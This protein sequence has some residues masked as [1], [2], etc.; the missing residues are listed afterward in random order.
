MYN[1][2][3]IIRQKYNWILIV[4]LSI[5]FLSLLFLFKYLFSVQNNVE[6]QIYDNYHNRE[7]IIYDSSEELINKL[8]KMQNVLFVYPDYQSL[9]LKNDT[10]GSFNIIP[11]LQ[12]DM[13]K[14]V[15]GRYPKNKNEIIVNISSYEKNIDLSKLSDKKVS[16]KLNDD[17]S[18]DFNIVGIF[19]SNS[20]SSNVYY[21]LGNINYL[22]QLIDYQSDNTRIIIDH[23]RNLDKVLSNIES[24]ASL[25][26]PSGLEE[27][28][29]YQNILKMILFISLIM[30]IFIFLMIIIVSTILYNGTKETR[31]IQFALGYTEG[32]IVK[33]YIDYYLKILMI[34]FIVSLVLYEI[35][36]L[37]IPNIFCIDNFI[38]LELFNFKSN[39][40][41]IIPIVII[42][43]LLVFILYFVIYCKSKKE[44]KI[45]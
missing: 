36:C 34:S 2:K 13:P 38:L 1:I 42:I 9:K 40:L 37:I 14:I 29:I 19:E 28:N 15:K 10:L 44:Y 7:I 26:N 35:V 39:Y 25:Y 27:I 3:R 31:F 8:N 5:L 43:I 11:L 24:S 4:I 33:S 21:N 17:I 22:L 41:F 16:F 23:Y 6:K 32:D 20:S 12:N 30:T 45:T 18:V